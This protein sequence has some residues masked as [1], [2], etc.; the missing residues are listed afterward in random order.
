MRLLLIAV[1]VVFA[2]AAAKAVDHVANSV[3]VRVGKVRWKAEDTSCTVVFRL[4][5]QTLTAK[6]AGVFVALY[7]SGDPAGPDGASG[8]TLCG[9]G[10]ARANLDPLQSRTIR[11]VVPTTQMATDCEVEMEASA[12]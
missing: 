2:V 3:P 11:I 1:I 4:H 6:R 9:S 7:H 5:N 10:A 12:R 8:K